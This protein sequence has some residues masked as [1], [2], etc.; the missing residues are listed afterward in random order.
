MSR[1]V[2][3]QRCSFVLSIKI[4]DLKMQSKTFNL[5][6]KK[7]VS[8][9]SAPVIHNEHRRL[10]G[11]C[12]PEHQVVKEAS[13]TNCALPLLANFPLGEV[14]LKPH[15]LSTHS[16]RT[17]EKRLSI[18]NNQSPQLIN[19]PQNQP[20]ISNN[21]DEFFKFSFFPQTL[22]PIKNLSPYFT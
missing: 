4:E 1:H 10:L 12:D 7:T 2:V 9:Y 22:N 5:S 15:T 11:K 16:F 6:M 8:K 21:P 18:L 17:Y 3:P 14:P 13:R 20:Q 19:R